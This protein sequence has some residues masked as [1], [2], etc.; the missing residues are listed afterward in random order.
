MQTYLHQKLIWPLKRMTYKMYIN[1]L[2]IYIFG[3]VIAVV[4]YYK[5]RDILIKKKPVKFDKV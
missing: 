5:I 4:A 2:F 1:K 3:I